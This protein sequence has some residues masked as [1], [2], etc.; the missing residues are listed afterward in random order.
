MDIL[1]HFEKLL[2]ELF[3]NLNFDSRSVKFLNNR[4]DPAPKDKET[5]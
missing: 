4:A 1:R 2:T 3:K 5:K